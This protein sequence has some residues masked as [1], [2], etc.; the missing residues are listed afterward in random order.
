VD[1]AVPRPDDDEAPI[2]AR[3]R[4]DRTRE[5]VLRAVGDADD[6]TWMLE[7]VDA[8]GRDAGAHGSPGGPAFGSGLLDLSGSGPGAGDVMVWTALTSPGAVR[9][10]LLLVNGELEMPA[11]EQDAIADVRFFVREAPRN[12]VVGAVALAADGREVARTRLPR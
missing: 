10:R 7:V 9:A 5:W 12:D 8:A 4:L 6:L 3:G 2:V 1:I 11:V